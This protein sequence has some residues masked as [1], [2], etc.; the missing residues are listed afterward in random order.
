MT[1]TTENIL[2]ISSLLL[3]AGVIAS[4]T[5]GKT[6]IPALLVFLGVGMLAGSDGLGGIMFDDPNLTQ[7]LGIIS[8]TFILFSGGLDTKW[9]SI[10]PV[11][12]QGISLSTVGVLLTSITLGA[13]VYWVSDLD[14]MESWLLGA[15]VS[16]TDA[17]AVF[18]ILRAKS[19][20]LKGNLRP[21]LELES[22]SNDPMAYFLTIALTSI[23]VAPD[24]NIWEIIPFFFVQM[25][26]GALVGWLMGRMC[27]LLMNKINLD[28]EGLY[29]VLMLALV[30]LTYTLTDLF[31]GNGFL[32]VY[33]C[34]LTVGNGKM[35]HKKSMM[36]FFDGVAWLMQVVMFITLGLLVFPTQMLPIIGISLTAALFLIL[37]ARPLGVFLA[38]A[39]FK[40]SLREKTFLSWVGLRGAV[41][42]VFA[43][44][45]MIAGL[46]SSGVIFHIVFF[47][48][49]TSVALQATTLPLAAKLLDLA[50][51]ASLKRKSLLDLELSDE[52][53]NA[54]IELDIPTESPATGKKILELDLP[55][56]CL[57]VL[58]NRNSQF[59][60]PNGQ[61]EIE[62]GDTLM[63]MLENTDQETIIKN[64]LL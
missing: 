6:G 43:T 18:S 54:L 55:S 28:F 40:F 47:I 42:I 9:P 41:P 64:A 62:A 51:P 61:T 27:V 34:A 8:L 53:K 3:F 38:L 36:K 46:P 15:I 7:F 49:L 16:S 31:S 37:V 5:S 26:V 35:V 56:T 52:F 10:K 60:T 59:I 33:I 17:A 4:K 21:L 44:I 29:P 23:I 24:Y 13:F 39:P 19:I 25:A 57:I 22:G 1:L 14:F 11:L 2:L 58:I 50:L 45:P 48:V 63:I 30:M 20:G 12:W 32:A